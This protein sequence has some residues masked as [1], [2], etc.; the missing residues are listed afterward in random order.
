MHTT[1]TSKGQLTLPKAL[2][3]KLQLAPG[4]RIEFVLGD[5]ETV[6]LVIKRQSVTRLRGV[7]AKPERPVS[8]DEMD[9]AIKAGARH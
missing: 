4:D 2:R 3:E 1:L 6:R 8:L 9:E 7:L 5:D